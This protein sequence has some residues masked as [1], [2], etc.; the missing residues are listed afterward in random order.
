MI[1]VL[2][3]AGGKKLGADIIMVHCMEFTKNK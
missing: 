2:E 1:G 3:E